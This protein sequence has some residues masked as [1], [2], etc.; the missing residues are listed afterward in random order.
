MGYLYTYEDK[1]HP[2]WIDHN[3]HLHD[4][5][6]FS[7]FSDAVVGFFAEMGFS[8]DYRQKHD[9]TIFNLEAHITFLKEMLLDETFTVEVHVY[10]YDKKRVHF[11]LKMFNQDQVPT[12]TYE[13]IM[14]AVD[15]KQ[16]RS[17]AFPEFVLDNIKIYYDEQG[18]F[19]T[20]KQL[21]HAIGIPRK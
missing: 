4:A 13:V 15:N 5:Q 1:V 10:D 16:R 2:S 19:E 18:T 21:G 6:Y 17:S 3:Q 8:I 14:M 7:I 11:F 20:P 9:T 12:A